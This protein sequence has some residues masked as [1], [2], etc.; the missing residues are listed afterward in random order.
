MLVSPQAPQPH[1]PPPQVQRSQNGDRLSQLMES[2]DRL[3]DKFCDNVE[4]IITREPSFEESVTV[5]AHLFPNQL[6][7]ADSVVGA[8][9]RFHGCRVPPPGLSRVTARLPLTWHASPSP[10]QRTP[11]APRRG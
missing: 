3:I 5:L 8:Q 9:G 6:L 7:T 1:L 4:D 10:A 2:R 11:A